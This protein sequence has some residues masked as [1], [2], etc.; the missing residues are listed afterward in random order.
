MPDADFVWS[1]TLVAADNPTGPPHTYNNANFTARNYARTT[2]GTGWGPLIADLAKTL[3]YSPKASSSTSHSAVVGSKTF[4]IVGGFGLYVGAPVTVVKS[5]TDY[6]TGQVTALD[7]PAQTITINITAVTSAFGAYGA[8]VIGLGTANYVMA[9]SPATIAQGGTGSGTAAGARTNLAI[10]RHFDIASV[11]S[12]PPGSPT[13]GETHIV[14]T[15]PTGA[16]VGHEHEITVYVTGTGWT[17]V[18]PDAGDTAYDAAAFASYVHTGTNQSIHGIYSGSRW[19]ALTN[20]LGRWLTGVGIVSHYSVV[21][22]DHGTWMAVSTSALL[23]ITLPS[24]AADS[25]AARGMSIVIEVPSSNGGNTVIAVSG[26]SNIRLADG[27]EAA[28]ITVTAGIY[29]CLHLVAGISGSINF[30]Y[31]WRG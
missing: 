1:A 19:K 12:T 13:N 18:V 11:V 28:S 17:F 4:A 7:L 27:T 2:P 9:T 6:M 20:V 30:W 15:A 31:V 24:I 23:N 25:G 3:E 14:G 5:A 10:K 26:G 21:T 16:Y 8:W 29:R 22:A